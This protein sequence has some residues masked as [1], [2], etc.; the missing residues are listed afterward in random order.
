L[1]LLVART[2]DEGNRDFPPTTFQISNIHAGTGASNVIPGSV[3]VVFNFR[4]STE[5]TADE[6]RTAVHELLDGEALDYQ[7]EW[8]HSGEPFLTPGGRLLE[9]TREA[10]RQVTGIDTTLSTGGGTSDGRFIAPTGA[11]VLELGPLNATIH[12]VDECVRLEDLE[13]LAEIYLE[14]MR[15]LLL[16]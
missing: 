13:R 5:V 2:W 16:G 6:L 3:E 7:I 10:I 15:R 9:V 12:K 4:Y 8:T 1:A 11:Q 14:I